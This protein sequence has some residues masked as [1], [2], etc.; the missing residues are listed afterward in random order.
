MSVVKPAVS[1]RIQGPL[2][3]IE[4]GAVDGSDLG[5]GDGADAVKRGVA[6]RT[7]PDIDVNAVDNNSRAEDWFAMDQRFVIFGHIVLNPFRVETDNQFPEGVD[8]TREDGA[9][10]LVVGAISDSDGHVAV[11]GCGDVAVE[12]ISLLVTEFYRQCEAILLIDFKT[13]PNTSKLQRQCGQ[14]A[15]GV[16]FAPETAWHRRDGRGEDRFTDRHLKASGGEQAAE[17]RLVNSPRSLTLH[18]L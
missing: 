13:S 7:W 11:F 3:L 6:D 18:W 9:D 1:Q 4:H 17:C 15:F 2:D 10:L 8:V 12:F 5:R 16:I 14:H